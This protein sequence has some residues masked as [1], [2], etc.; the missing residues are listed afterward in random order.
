MDLF[1][2]KK[3]IIILEIVM[4]LYLETLRYK[5]SKLLEIGE[6]IKDIKK[7]KGQFM[8][9]FYIPKDKRNLILDILKNKNFKKRHLTFFINYLVRKKVNVSIIKYHHHW[10]RQSNYPLV[11]RKGCYGLGSDYLLISVGN[12]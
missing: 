11:T 10:Y 1:L 4:I 8:G 12:R 2:K 5:N 6:K 7:V 3:Y 9:L